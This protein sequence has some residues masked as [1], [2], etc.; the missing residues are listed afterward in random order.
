M[1]TGIEVRKRSNRTVYRAVVY[2]KNSDRKLTKTFDTLAGARGWRADA[3][4]ALAAGTLSGER[5]PTLKEAVDQWLAGARAAHVRNRSGDVYK[6]AAIRDYE[7][8]LRLRVLPDYGTSR[9]ADIRHRD[10]HAL[11]DKLVQQ[12]H[13]ASTVHGTITPLRAIYRRALSRGVVAINPT[14]GLE[15]PAVRSQPRRYCSPVEAERL[16]AALPV[17]DR[18]MWA[19]A[20][21]A[22]LRRGE[23]TGLQWEDV[24]LADGIIHVRRGWDHLE[25]EITPKSHKGRRNVPIP[26]ILRDYLV[27]HRMDT[28]D[29][30]RVFGGPG[31]VRARTERAA[32]TWADADLAGVTLH[33]ARHTYASL[34]IAAGVNAK[35]LSTFMGHATIAV[36]IDLYGHLMPGSEAQAADLLDDYLARSAD[37]TSPMT[38]PEAVQTAA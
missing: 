2:D 11:V 4:S 5:G 14:R 8:A 17:E 29:R 12:G 27:R 1:A 37:P 31:P 10:L 3:M 26:A 36:T 18:A 22:G 33:E 34:M 7:K 35:A 38:S 23:L 13:S 24:N 15:L 16:L 9:L 6:P 28:G 32:K 30:L 19:T 21:Y 25:G 20:F